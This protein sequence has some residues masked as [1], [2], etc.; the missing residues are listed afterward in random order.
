M[1]E[2]I[3]D[4]AVLDDGFFP[5]PGAI[6]SE[7][8][9]EPEG[10]EGGESAAEGAEEEG[11]QP[12]VD[13][14]LWPDGHPADNLAAEA[15][16]IAARER[17]EVTPKKASKDQSRFEYWQ[18]EAT[19]FKNQAE[20]NAQL[21]QLGAK[22]A[23]NPALLAQLAAV[24]VAPVALVA[25][26][27]LV[28]QE[29]EQKLEIPKAPAK[30][31]NFNDTEAYS[32]PQSESFKYR[33]A[34]DQHRDDMIDYYAKKE[35]LREKREVAQRKQLEQRAAEKRQLAAVQSQ[36]QAKYGLTAQEA[37]LFVQQ[38]TKPESVTM[39]NL[40]ALF[41]MRSRGQAPVKTGQRKSELLDRANRSAAPLPAAV[42]GGEGVDAGD[43]ESQ[44]NNGLLKYSHKKRK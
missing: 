20:A 31:T 42:A 43:D 40:V 36:V 11:N 28:A 15:E 34:K 12:A 3:E 35:E 33:I 9:A 8:V 37:V 18:S 14:E 32:D 4:N 7:A 25:D 41:K 27:A 6:A 17:G 22:V 13:S 23:Q 24:P 21:A 26:P 5:S 2:S 29:A 44:F 1:P 30:P 10:S 19:K 16:A 39:D 38:M